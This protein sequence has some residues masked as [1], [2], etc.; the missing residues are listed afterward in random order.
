M[1]KQI[2]PL[3]GPPSFTSAPLV[4]V[5]VLS[6]HAMIDTLC[7]LFRCFV[8]VVLISVPAVVLNC[9]FFNCLFWV[10]VLYQREILVVLVGYC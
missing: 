3:Y 1:E 6:V 9:F 4:L 5:P 10:A 2:R 7:F 8:L